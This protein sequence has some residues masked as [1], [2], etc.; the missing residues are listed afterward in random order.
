MS[1][2][3]LRAC[4]KKT[5]TTMKPPNYID[6]K[7]FLVST[8]FLWIFLHWSLILTILNSKRKK[9]LFHLI[10]FR[11]K[12]IDIFQYILFQ[13]AKSSNFSVD[14]I[15]F[16]PKEFIIFSLCYIKQKNT[17]W[18]LITIPCY[19]TRNRSLIAVFINNE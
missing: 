3:W 6:F 14:S 13:H 7:P 11:R 4:S 12:T 9:E 17:T 16:I 1:I 18:R 8:I 2:L 19:W 15:Q 10:Q 5:F